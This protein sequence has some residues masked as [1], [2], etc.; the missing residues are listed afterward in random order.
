MTVATLTT[1]GQLPI[2]PSVREQL[3]L[4]PGDL[5]DVT[6]EDRRIVLHPVTSPPFRQLDDW[7]PALQIHRTLDLETLCAPVDVNE[8][9]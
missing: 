1:E 8:M 3:Q 6:V 2:P 5:L 7:L 4:K 9:A